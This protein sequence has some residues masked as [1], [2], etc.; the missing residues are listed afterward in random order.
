[1]PDESDSGS[2][3]G[4]R[5]AAPQAPRRF[6]LGDYPHADRT[7]Q[8]DPPA[9]QEPRSRRS[10][11]RPATNRHRGNAGGKRHGRKLWL[12]L[13]AGGAAVVAVVVAV[14]LVLASGSG[15]PQHVLVTPAKV[16]SWIRSTT[17]AKQ[18]DVTQLEKNIINQSSGSASHLVSA[19]YQD[20]PTTVGGSP[21][22]VMLFI[23][24]RLAGASPT[25]ALKEFTA[26]F[27]D[28]QMVSVGSFGGEATCVDGPASANGATAVC[29]W[30]D[31]DT[32][33][34]LVSANMSVA[35]LGAEMHAI[36]PSLELTA[37]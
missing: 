28:P 27:S 6:G 8:S 37:K 32:F 16:G 15:G 31:N 11:A 26:R 34:E 33:G 23:G 36:R 17:L 5:T 1:M 2:S 10:S 29:A 25:T 7:D 12:G 35:A 22:P 21:P 20:G 19:V 14:V 18:M 24:G 3:D 9:K 30:F 13:G 4:H